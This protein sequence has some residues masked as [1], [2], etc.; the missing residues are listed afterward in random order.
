MF[1]KF[2]CEWI[3]VRAVHLTLTQTTLLIIICSERPIAVGANFPQKKAEWTVA[4][5]LSKH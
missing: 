4:N 3:E 5:A 1:L 2:P